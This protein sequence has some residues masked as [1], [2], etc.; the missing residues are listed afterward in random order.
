MV[1]NLILSGKVRAPTLFN[2]KTHYM[3][4]PKQLQY[5]K[6]IDKYLS[7]TNTDHTEIINLSQTKEQKR[8]IHWRQG[9]LFSKCWL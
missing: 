2:F 5:G 7:G 6:I 8:G 1:A 9:H 4:Y 3:Q